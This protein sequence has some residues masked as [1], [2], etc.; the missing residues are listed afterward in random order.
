M[1]DRGN[2]Q[3]ERV[4]AHD[5]RGQRLAAAL[6]ANLV[7]RKK[8]ALARSRANERDYPAETAGDD[9]SGSAAAEM[10]HDSAEIVRDKTFD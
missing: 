6:R 7:R 2:R 9:A 10:P 8:Q 5:G 3:S 4:V 1:S